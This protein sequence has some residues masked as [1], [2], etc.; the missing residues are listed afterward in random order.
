MQKEEAKD[1]ELMFCKLSKS[2]RQR[3]SMRTVAMWIFTRFT[4]RLGSKSSN[5]THKTTTD[6]NRQ[7]DVFESSTHSVTYVYKH[8]YV[9]M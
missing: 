1:G 5:H 3:D 7:E 6:C 9:S 8:I 4:H 2:R